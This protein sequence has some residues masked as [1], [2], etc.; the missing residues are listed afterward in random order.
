M[1]SIANSATLI[2]MSGLVLQVCSSILGLWLS[3]YLPLVNYQGTYQT[4]VIAGA[5]LGFVNVFI[6]PIVNLITLPLRLL[7]LG[8]FTIIINMFIIWMIDIIFLGDIFTWASL[9]WATVI[10]GILNL[11]FSSNQ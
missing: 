5:V 6:K 11:M 9:F 7:T 3:T 1:S 2:T 10:V 8:L 4:L